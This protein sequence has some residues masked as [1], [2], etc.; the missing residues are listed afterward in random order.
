MTHDSIG[1]GEDGPTHQPI[2]TLMMIR[3]MPNILLIR[4]CDGNETSGSYAVALQHRHQPSVLCFSR[5]VTPNLKGTSIEGVYKGAYVL[6]EPEG[7]PQLI[8][9]ASGTE[10]AIAIEASKLLKDLKVRVVSMP[11]WELFQQQTLEYKQS[12]LLDGVP[13]FAVEA[14]SSLGWREYAHAC[15]GMTTFGASG[16]GP[17]LYQHFGFTAENISNKARQV[18]EFYAKH[19]IHN[20]VLRPF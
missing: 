3:A 11:C 12:I 13:V 9:V 5:Q 14:G 16:P 1:L 17:K 19:P 2:E 7:T 20:L 18:V 8:F 4:P 6:V 15:W 10:V